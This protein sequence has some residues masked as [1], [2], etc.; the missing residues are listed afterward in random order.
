MARLKKLRLKMN[1]SWREVETRPD[2]ILLDLLRED[3]GLTGTKKG[4]ELKHERVP[5]RNW[6]IRSPGRCVW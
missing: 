5:Q 4:C 2:R 3:L 1:G 6:P